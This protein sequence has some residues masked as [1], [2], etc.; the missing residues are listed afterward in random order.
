[1]SDY[2]P[3]PGSK[4]YTALC[5]FQQNIERALSSQQLAGLL[6][7]DAKKIPAL[8][9]QV[10]ATHL[11]AKRKQGNGYVWCL[12]ERKI[13][14]LALLE[15]D[16]ET[17][18]AQPLAVGPGLVQGRRP[19]EGDSM[20]EYV[21]RAGS[22]AHYAVRYF[23][24]S[25]DEELSSNQLAQMLEVSQAK[26]PGL[27]QKAERSQLL[28]KR[29]LSNGFV[30]GLGERVI[31]ALVA[32]DAPA[33]TDDAGDADAEGDFAFALW[34]DGELVINGAMQ[35]EHGI[36]LTVQQTAQLVAY[37]TSTAAYVEYLGAKQAP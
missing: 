4:A 36:Q 14:E 31:D 15:P 10:E 28:R 13:D 11:L 5:Y 23:Q 29:K 34:Q 3:R 17:A 8:L 20:K 27:L 26:L 32:P 21:P 7:I 18:P 2:T 1:M 16:E 25:P 12:G 6:G 30:W 35:T 19:N 37:L 33:D 24:E 9:H 22:A